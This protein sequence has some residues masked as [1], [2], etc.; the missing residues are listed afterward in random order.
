LEP[1]HVVALYET[2]EGF[3]DIDGLSK[4]VTTEEIQAQ[5]GNLNI[6]AY[7]SKIDDEVI[8]SV[9]EAT[10]ALKAA[11][12]KAWAAEDELNKLLVEMEIS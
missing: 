4:V 3:G 5:D 2:Y 6:T 10:A 7:V 12:D 9:E 11:L 1:E 8:P